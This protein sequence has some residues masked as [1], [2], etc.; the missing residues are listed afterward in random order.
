M[1]PSRARDSNFFV[2]KDGQW[3]LASV[4][5]AAYVPPSNYENLRAG[6]GHRRVGWMKT[7]GA[8]SR[9]SHSH[10][11]PIKKFRRVTFQTSNGQARAI[12]LNLERCQKFLELL[13]TS[14]IHF[15]SVGS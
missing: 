13:E 7:R 8:N 5:E 14:P 10:G 2:K 9:A 15:T 3:L 11:R 4:R 12:V 6:V 1:A